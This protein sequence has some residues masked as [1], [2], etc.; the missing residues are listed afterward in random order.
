[1][2]PVLDFLLSGALKPR[3]HAGVGFA[4]VYLPSGARLH[5]WHPAFPVEPEAFGLR[6][7]HRFDMDSTVLLGALV[8]TPFYLCPAKYGAFKRYTVLA[9]H[10]GVAEKPQPVIEQRYSIILDKPEV[11][12]AGDSYF[13]AKRLY[14]QSQ[15]FGVTV[16]LMEK[17]NQ[18]DFRA[19]IIGAHDAEPK[20]GLDHDVSDDDVILAMAEA[21]R[22]L[23]PEA[24]AKVVPHLTAGD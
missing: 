17:S 4:Q 10:H 13:F 16:T 1:M 18:E 11:Y 2:N 5:V 24:I 20:H 14:H 6:H 3:F 23:S 21:F 12:R 19:E 22:A 8:H 15:G 9:A 7:N